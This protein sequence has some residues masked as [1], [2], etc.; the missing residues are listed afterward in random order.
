VVLNRH[1]QFADAGWALQEL[2]L[3][4][5]QDVYERFEPRDELLEIK[6]LFD[7]HQP[8][9]PQLDVSGTLTTRLRTKDAVQQFRIY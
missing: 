8:A 5:I 1:R 4:T 2:E 7:E 3:L 6:W 9:L